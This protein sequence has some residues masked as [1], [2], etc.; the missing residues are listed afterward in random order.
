MISVYCRDQAPHAHG[1]TGARKKKGVE[2][3]APG[4]YRTHVLTISY[5]VDLVIFAH[6]AQA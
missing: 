4:D 6:V 3:R 1:S 5:I 2:E